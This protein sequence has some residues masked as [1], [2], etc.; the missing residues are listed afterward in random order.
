MTYPT[1]LKSCRADLP[2][3]LGSQGVLRRKPQ[4]VT[5]GRPTKA[6]SSLPRGTREDTAQRSA[7]AVLGEREV[8]LRHIRT[9]PEA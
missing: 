7:N 2:Y 6:T 5:Q 4:A 9:L 3:L 8:T 1:L